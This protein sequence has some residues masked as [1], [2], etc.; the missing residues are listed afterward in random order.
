MLIESFSLNELDT[1]TY[2]VSDGHAA[3]IIDP[4]ALDMAPVI[5]YIAKRELSVAALVN[6]HCHFDHVLGNEPLR[7]LYGAPLY[8]NRAELAILRAAPRTAEIW[9]GVSPAVREP[10]GFLAEGAELAV[11]EL[12]LVVVETPGHSPGG[13]CLHAAG[14]RVLFTGDTLFAGTIGR[15]DLPGGDSARLMDSLRDK[16]WPLPDETVI[17]PGHGE[18]STIGEERTHNPFFRF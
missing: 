12:R 14:Q 11:G 10:D 5:A 3:V 16:L 7:A 18:A 8:A 1:N 17:F 6:T 2:V 9:T 15:T 13:I 4:C